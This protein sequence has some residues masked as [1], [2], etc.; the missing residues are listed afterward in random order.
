[1]APP[2]SEICTGW[3]RAPSPTRRAVPALGG[4]PSDRQNTHS[5]GSVWSTTGRAVGTDDQAPSSTDV[6]DTTPLPFRPIRHLQLPS[7]VRIDPSGK[8][9]DEKYDSADLRALAIAHLSIL[10]SL[11]GGGSVGTAVA[12]WSGSPQQGQEVVTLITA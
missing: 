5:A 4:S 12:G 10:A 7:S 6:S 11:G 8:K 3:S 1:M 2:T 9:L